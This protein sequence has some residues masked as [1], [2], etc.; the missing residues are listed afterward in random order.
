MT[1]RSFCALS[2][3]LMAVGGLVAPAF[4]QGYVLAVPG[5]DLVTKLATAQ[6]PG[7]PGKLYI[8]GGSGPYTISQPLVI[9]RS[10]TI[11]G[12]SRDSVVIQP[13]NMW[14]GGQAVIEMVGVPGEGG[15]LVGVRVQNLTIG[16]PSRNLDA[17]I[18]LGRH[19]SQDYSVEHVVDNV[20]VSGNF[21]AAVAVIGTECST[22]RDCTLLSSK[23]SGCGLYASSTNGKGIR[24]VRAGSLTSPTALN[25]GTTTYNHVSR[26]EIG[27]TGSAAGGNCV[28]LESEVGQ[29]TFDN[30]H[31][32]LSSSSTAYPDACVR[33][34]RTTNACPHNIRLAGCGN[35]LEHVTYGVQIVGNA[36]ER[37]VVGLT[38]DTC[39]FRTQREAI[40][41][42]SARATDLFIFN[43]A[44]EWGAE[45]AWADP[46][47]LAEL[48]F[49][50][51]LTNSWI[52][53]RNS[54]ARS[55]ESL[56]AFTVDCLVYV[57]AAEDPDT[58]IVGQVSDACWVAP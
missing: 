4:G 25:S 19:G 44:F 52:C 53:L 21:V 24:S 54:S 39:H 22:L 29:W 2:A 23:A 15:D 10:V 40:F 13:A 36:P 41:A 50:G 26:C 47:E 51:G 1:R 58:S 48:R 37:G 49:L 57:A 43:S 3:L 42:A 31:F 18:I 9:T 55:F 7:G 28:V 12:A 45:A 6:A 16:S 11:E 46:A 56:S 14:L 38:L 17:G 32:S 27:T 30:V 33:L 34:E 35:D 8:R 20:K 5:D